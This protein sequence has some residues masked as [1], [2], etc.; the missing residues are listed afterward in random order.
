MSLRAKLKGQEWGICA[1]SN[2]HNKHISKEAASNTQEL[3]S[4]VK[5]NGKLIL[6]CVC[7]FLITLNNTEH[8]AKSENQFAAPIPS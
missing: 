2:K 8:L 1:R 6:V 4:P 7:Q 5:D 3:A